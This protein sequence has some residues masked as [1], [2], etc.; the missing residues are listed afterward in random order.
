MIIIYLFKIWF[1]RKVA[2]LYKVKSKKLLN[3]DYNKYLKLM[4]LCNKYENKANIIIIYKLIG[5]D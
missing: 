2:Y 3:I 4:K 1:Y 5:N